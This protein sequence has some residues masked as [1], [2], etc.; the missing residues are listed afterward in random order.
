MLIILGVASISAHL[1]KLMVSIYQVFSGSTT[2]RLVRA[3]GGLKSDLY[4]QGWVEAR[5]VWAWVGC[6]QICLGKGG[7]KPDWYGQGWV[8]ARLVWERVG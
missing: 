1:T 4:G 6:S 8:E 7:L 3:R 5:L 2:G